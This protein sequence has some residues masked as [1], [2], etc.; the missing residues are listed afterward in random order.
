MSYCIANGLGNPRPAG[1]AGIPALR[2]VW[3]A[4]SGV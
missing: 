2:C 1:N 3:L 4:C